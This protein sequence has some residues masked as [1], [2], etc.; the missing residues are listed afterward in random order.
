MNLKANRFIT[1]IIFW[2]IIK[3]NNGV[4]I[5]DTLSSSIR[6]YSGQLTQYG[7]TQIEAKREITKRFTVDP[8]YYVIIPN[9][10]YP[11]LN[12]YMLSKVFIQL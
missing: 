3:V 9:T 2:I 7:M 12:G 10:Y 6:L 1:T 5:N 11:G 8:G 4:K